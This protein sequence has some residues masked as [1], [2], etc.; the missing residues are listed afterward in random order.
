MPSSLYRSLVKPLLFRVD[1]ERAHTLALS[2]CALGGRVPGIAQLVRSSQQ[3]QDSR[4]EQTIAGIRFQNPLGLAAGFDKNGQACELLGSLA[5]GFIEIGSISA[6]R[7]EGNAP[8]RLFRIIE[9]EGIVV[10][11]GVPN[12]GAEVVAK[13]LNEQRC[14]IPLGANLVKTNDPRRPSEDDEVFADY[15]SSFQQLQDHSQYINLNLS[16]PNSE[17]DRDFFDDI[18]KIEMLL[19]RLDGLDPTI[20]VFLKLKPTA[21]AGW[22]REL[23]SIA[24]N[25]QWIKGFGINLPSGK[26]KELVLK[27]SREALEKM[28]GAVSGRPIE[29]FINANLALLYQTIGPDSRYALMGAGGVFTG[30]DAYRKIRLGASLVQ[31]YT[32]MVYRGPGVVKE[33]LLQLSDRLERDGFDNISQAVGKDV[34]DFVL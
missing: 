22:L 25:Y 32:A 1:P 16:C 19:A 7:S 18:E 27:S 30:E 5:F 10:Y 6:Y 12:E 20:P 11:Y 26:P 13:R 4:L 34:K 8:P 29:Q 33:V 14:P 23:I 24:D 3:I 2:L 17:G 21:D 31:L 28:P 15:A 9:D